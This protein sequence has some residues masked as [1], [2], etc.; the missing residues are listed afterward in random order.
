MHLL[1][2]RTCISPYRSLAAVSVALAVGVALVVPWTYVG[3]RCRHEVNDL[4]NLLQQSRWG[5]A[6]TLVHDLLALDSGL[7]WNGVPL[8]KLA[9]EIDRAVGDLESR[10]ALPLAARAPVDERL[11]RARDLAML[12]R[13]SAALE[14]LTLPM[15]AANP[16]A[17]NLAGTIHENRGD[18]QAA[19]D[20]FTRAM[21][22]WRLQPSSPAQAEGLL[23]ATTGI[24]YCQRKSGHYSQAEATYRQLLDLSPT[25]DSYFLLAQFYEDSQQAEQARVHARRAMALAPEKYGDQGKRLIDKL[26][27]HHFGCLSVYA[28]ESAASLR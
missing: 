9:V 14:L 5:E 23:R 1:A 7:A 15:L 16:E 3:A 11:D 24:A 21:A 8:S 20:A 10:A 6:R 25:A 2:R 27:L 22:E 4:G 18:W 13:T 26:T 19:L 28:A 17:G 12:G